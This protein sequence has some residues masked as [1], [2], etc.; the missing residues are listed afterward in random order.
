LELSIEVAL[1]CAS[2]HIPD[3][4]SER[5]VWIAATAINAGFTLVTRNM[6]DFANM[7][8]TPINPFER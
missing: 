4:K 1:I 7:G 2:L 6:G 8:I 5:D 3:P